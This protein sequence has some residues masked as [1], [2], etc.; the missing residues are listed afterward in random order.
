MFII[1]TIAACASLGASIGGAV[2]TIAGTSVAAG[3]A[4]GTV[5]AV[6]VSVLPLA[7]PRQ[8]RAVRALTP[9]PPPL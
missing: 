3:T 6:P 5:A 4:V 1:S 8:K 9:D 7:L 2:A